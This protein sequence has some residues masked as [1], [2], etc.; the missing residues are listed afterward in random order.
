M[1]AESEGH[2]R[3]PKSNPKRTWPKK[4]PIADEEPSPSSPASQSS[5]SSSKSKTP[6][7]L[8]SSKEE[9]GLEFDLADP[10][11]LLRKMENID[12]TEEET[13]EL[14]KR[15]YEIN[16]QLRDAVDNGQPAL[17]RG[18]GSAPEGAR[19]RLSYDR[20]QSRGMMEGDHLPQLPVGRQTSL[21]SG[22]YS[23]TGVASPASSQGS[24]RYTSYHS[25]QV[26]NQ[27]ITLLYCP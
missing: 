26:C 8:T 17:E 21:S 20:P 14:L 23:R 2:G 27:V 13:E 3:K 7:W 12:L 22:A 25:A 6:S 4:S 15:A 18:G 19:S 5:K 11:D 16:K 24:T 10:E 9:A 1:A